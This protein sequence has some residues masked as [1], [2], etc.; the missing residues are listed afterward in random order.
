MQKYCFNCMN[1]LGSSPFCGRCGCDSRAAEPSAAYHL[2]RGTMLANRYIIGKTLGEGGFGI[3]YIGM[4]TTLSK[5]VAVKEFYPAG[6]ATR[7][8]ALTKDVSVP[9]D[10]ERFFRKGVER[11]LFE[12][13]SV[14]AF[15]DEEGI[16]NVQD[17][18]HENKTAY[19]V[20]DY[21]DGDTLK[22]Y[23]LRH[24][25]FRFD[26]LVAL[27][28]PVMKALGEMHA[29]GIIHRDISPDNILFNAKGNLKLTDFGS[30][31]YF[32]GDERQKAIILKQG[33]APEEQYRRDGDQG[34]HTD[35]YALCATIYYCITGKPPVPSTERIPEDTIESPSQLGADIRPSQEKAL[36]RGLAVLA[37]N[38][39]PD[40]DTL[41]F[42]LTGQTVKSPVK[43]EPVPETS[44]DTEPD[45]PELPKAKP[46]SPNEY[47][48]ARK[49]DPMLLP[50][51]SYQKRARQKPTL[52]TVAV[53]LIPVVLVIAL[54]IG[55]VAIAG[56]RDSA[57]ENSD[58]TE[59]GVNIADLLSGIDS[60]P[61]TAPAGS[62]SGTTAPPETTVPRP[63]VTYDECRQRMDSLRT[64]FFDNVYSNDSEARY[65]NVIQLRQ[66]YYSENSRDPDNT[67]IAFLYLNATGNY[68]KVLYLPANSFSVDGETLVSHTTYMTQC[69]SGSNQLEA[70]SKCWFLSSTL[71][72]NSVL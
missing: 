3:T 63:A 51:K 48:D 17:Y 54:I 6:I 71:Y 57:P 65:A 37:K 1:L 2:P 8:C 20:M 30:A 69:A 12:A 19:I 53:I 14:A 59:S 45:E 67:Y 56:S 52:P 61:P 72:I 16:V 36:M 29:N 7:D 50:T 49:K 28:M 4:D 15:S 42:E 44:P 40:M 33:F 23:V 10:R 66:T 25:T 58:S 47:P 60:R 21:L 22:E 46:A 70:M 64:F 26:E 43:R 39:T 31:K 9:Q 38:R 55:A 24:G 34:P 62:A 68:Y 18:F 13:K 32:T 35:V 11:F 41:I 27:L 5:R